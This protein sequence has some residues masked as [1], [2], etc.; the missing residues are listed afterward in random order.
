MDR[1]V[2]RRS[3]TRPKPRH[4]HD[5]VV[6]R[7]LHFEAHFYLFTQSIWEHYVMADTIQHVSGTG[8]LAVV[9][10]IRDVQSPTGALPVKRR[11]GRPRKVELAPAPDEAA[12]HALMVEERELQLRTD[13]VVAASD[14]TPEEVLVALRTAAAREAAGLLFERR[15]LEA[16]GSDVA[17]IC[18]RRVEALTAVARLTLELARVRAGTFDPY[19]RDMQLIYNFFL[20]TV[21][22]S[23]TAVLPPDT[24]AALV[25]AFET[26]LAGWEAQF[27]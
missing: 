24:A 26:R 1:R 20:D 15:R 14:G 9:V 17:Q 25:E 27:E 12:Y 21:R 11:P 19:S 8:P 13:S 22:E 18:S 16:R 4:W 10:P 3:R 5:F 23:T 6:L 2:A 7:P